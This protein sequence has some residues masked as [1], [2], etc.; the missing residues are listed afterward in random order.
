MKYCQKLLDLRELKNLKQWEVG[1]I[2][3]VCQQQYDR[4][5]K[6]HFQMPIEKYKILALHYNV[7]VDYLAGLIPNPK[8]LDGT[9]FDLSKNYKI[10]NTGTITN[11]G[12]I[13]NHP[14]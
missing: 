9:P 4:W 10:T 2:L 6:G 14:K 5:E 7:S 8:T 3:G 11:N 13:V 1:E 12:K